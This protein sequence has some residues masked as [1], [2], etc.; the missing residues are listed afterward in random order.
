MIQDPIAPAPA[1][2]A[3]VPAAGRRA[4][5]ALALYLGLA[6]GALVPPAGAQFDQYSMP[7]RYGEQR[8]PKADLI[9]RSLREARW[10]LGR[11]YLDPWI[12]L[13]DL[14][15]IDNVTS[16][17]GGP[18]VSDVT[19]TAGAGLRGYLPFSRVTLAVH[20]LPEYVWWRD[21][22]DRR[23]WNGRYGAGLFGSFG[24]ARLEI[25][26]RLTEDASFVSR[27]I[28]EKVNT[29]D[30]IGE[31]ALEVD[32]GRGL[33]VFAAASARSASFN[34]DH[35]D[36][37]L[38][39]LGRLE[40]DEELFEV[41]LEIRLPRDW[42]LGL[43][44]ESSTVDFADSSD[45][46]NSGISPLLRLEHSQESLS[47]LAHLAWRDLE[48]ED[49][50]RFV[51]YDGVTCKLRVSWRSSSRLELELFGDRNLVYSTA[52]DWAYFED[53]GLGAAIRLALSS[54]LNVRLFF[55]DGSADYA[56]F[57]ASAPRRSDDYQAFGGHFEFRLGRARVLAGGSQTDYDSNLPG[58][59]RKVTVIRSALRFG[60]GSASP[61]G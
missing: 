40:R 43:G 30:E 27:E 28:E 44:V 49:G 20:A 25:T 4:A 51:P 45:R 17:T 18:K 16:Q 29:R 55:E 59:D 23:R 41:G 53:T 46:S 31:A 19:V 60:L 26:A 58:F 37:L 57:D 36:V 5:A 38:A 48:A 32:L 12:A 39:E 24:P 8:Q 34:A 22:A 9:D 13:D 52:D 14:A 7:G 3:S 35:D 56:G 33:S 6:L 11:I 50:G 47:V 10:K 54:R 42:V 15:Y 21:L 2:A 61:W 1:A